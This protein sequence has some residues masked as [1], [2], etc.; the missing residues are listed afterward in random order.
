MSY[1]GVQ[2][3]NSL[4]VTSIIF[5]LDVRLSADDCSSVRGCCNIYQF[6]LPAIA[7]DV[8]AFITY[9][10]TKVASAEENLHTPVELSLN[11]P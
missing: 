11:G 3:S 2:T 4:T 5:K 7:Y 6:I 1:C 10:V 8:Y 9:L